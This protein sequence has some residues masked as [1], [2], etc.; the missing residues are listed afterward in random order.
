MR[1]QQNTEQAARS[2]PVITSAP[3]Q[4]DQ[5]DYKPKYMVYKAHPL[6]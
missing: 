4:D 6:L 3:L 2:L 1:I 5:P